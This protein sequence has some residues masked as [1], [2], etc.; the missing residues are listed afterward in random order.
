MGSVLS[1]FLRWSS[2]ERNHLHLL[3]TA[4][5]ELLHHPREPKGYYADLFGIA[6]C[7]PTE[8]GDSFVI[9]QELEEEY[10]FRNP[11]ARPGW[12]NKRLKKAYELL[13][14]DHP[15]IVRYVEPTCFSST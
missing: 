15:R 1:T 10:G 14:G 6:S 2:E 9:C 7:V 3:P 8:N 11:R 12:A 13:D 4:E 5:H